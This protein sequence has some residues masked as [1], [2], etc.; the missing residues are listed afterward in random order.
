M[1]R[2]Y[3]VTYLGAISTCLATLILVNRTTKKF[4]QAV[5]PKKGISL[6]TL[7]GAVEKV[8]DLVKSFK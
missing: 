6:E 4:G 2:S 7:G 3:F 1:K 8:I 5:K